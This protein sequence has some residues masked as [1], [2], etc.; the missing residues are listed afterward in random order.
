METKDISGVEIFS[1]GVWNGDKYT[2]GDLDQMVRAFEETSKGYRPFLKLGHNNEQKLLAEDGLPAAGYIGRLY[3]MGEKLLADFVDIPNKIALLIEKKAYRKVSSEI[4][5]N[6]F[7]NEKQYSHLLGA[8]ALLGA[9][10]PGVQNLDDI[11]KMYGLK[12]YASIKSYAK[13]DEALT[14]K[15]FTTINSDYQE[16]VPMPKTELEL[17]LERKLLESDKAKLAT[18][19][20]LKTFRSDAESKDKA[21]EAQKKENE[22]LKAKLFKQEQDAKKANIDA[23]ADKMV[24]DK[25]ITKGMKPFVIQLLSDEP[26]SKK[27]SFKVGDKDVEHDKVGLITEIAKLFKAK[28]TVN[29][30]EGSE[31]GADGKGDKDNNLSDVQVAE[32]EKYAADNK[33]SFTDAYKKLFKGKLKQS[34]K[35]MGADDNDDNEE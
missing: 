16:D 6:A 30:E 8:V 19:N 14:V 34:T 20:E 24:S 22:E 33:V 32:V 1:A 31:L 17:D 21:I 23:Q 18:E 11:L 4:Y 29:L 7:F 12:D 35:S 15:T 25:L 28:G 26:E 9:D 2:T 5:L 13:S 10:M 27:F 3:R